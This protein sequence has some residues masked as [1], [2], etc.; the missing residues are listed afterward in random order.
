MSKLKKNE[1]SHEKGI[2]MW[3]VLRRCSLAPYIPDTDAHEYDKAKNTVTKTGE[4][5]HAFNTVRC[6]AGIM[7]ARIAVMTVIMKIMT[8]ACGILKSFFFSIVN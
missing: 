2:L 5:L 4:H 6:T 7:L 1:S 3:P 8:Y